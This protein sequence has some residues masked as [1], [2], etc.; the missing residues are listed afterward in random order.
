MYEQNHSL[1]DVDVRYEY[2]VIYVY[3]MKSKNYI[4]KTITVSLLNAMKILVVAIKLYMVS[5]K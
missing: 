1:V 2:M 4:N 5:S 3:L